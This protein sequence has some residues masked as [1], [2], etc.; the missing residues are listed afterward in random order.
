MEVILSNGADTALEKSNSRD[1]DLAHGAS[2]QKAERRIRHCGIDCAERLH[3][4]GDRPVKSEACKID[5]RGEKNVALFQSG[6]SPPRR[7]SQQRVVESIRTGSLAV[8]EDESTV[9]RVAIG[10]MMIHARGVEILRGDELCGDNILPDIAFHDSI[11]Q[12]KQL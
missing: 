9:D 12:R 10:K 2:G 1:V 3:L 5:H 8:V 6:S 4:F 7:G 11:R